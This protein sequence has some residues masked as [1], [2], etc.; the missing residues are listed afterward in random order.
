MQEVVTVDR[1]DNTIG[2]MEKMTAHKLGVLHRAFSV[3]VFNSNKQLLIHQRAAEKY[4]GG[5]LWTNTCCSH[6]NPGE[7]VLQ[8]A[9]RRLMEEM[10]MQTDLQKHFDFVY[11]TEVENNLIEHEFDH[12]FVGYSDAIPQPN[13]HEVMN[14]KWV[15]LD[16]LKSDINSHPANYTVWFKLAM[17]ELFTASTK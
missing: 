10:G 11:K 5:G 2:K 15:D 7:L 1:Y 14:W 8:A 17:P 4:H 6:P 16:W 3:F 9:H 12:V 13:K